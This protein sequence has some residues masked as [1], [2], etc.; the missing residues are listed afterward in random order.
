[1]I[2]FDASL[3]KGFSDSLLRQRYDAPIPTPTL[4]EEMWEMCCSDNKLVAIAA[5]R[6]HAKSTA[7]THAYTL[8][9]ICFR[10][11]KF[12]II[13]SD[14]EAQAVN[15]LGDIKAELLENQDLRGLFG[16]D[17]LLKDNETDCILQYDDGTKC[18][19]IA[20]GA[21]QKLRGLKWRGKRPDLIV[22]DDMENDESVEN[23]ERR[24]KM[25]LWFFKA[26][27][28]S[29][30]PDGVIR[31][32]GTVLHLDALLERLLNDSTW[33]TKRYKAH[34]EDYSEILWP[35]L[36]TKESLKAIQQS[37]I[38]QGMPEGYSCE[39][40]NNPIDVSDRL[41]RDQDFIEMKPEDFNKPMVY[42]ASS[43]FAISQK[44]KADYTVMLV[45]GICPEGYLYI[46]DRIK[47]RMDSEEIIEE[48]INI[49]KRYSPEVFLVEAEKIDKAIGPFLR[50]RMMETGVFINVHTETPTKDKISR[51]SSIAA[52]MKQGAV[53]F[54]KENDWYDNFYEN[55]CVVTRSGVKGAHDDDLDAFAWLGL[56]IDKFWNAP[57]LEEIEEEQYEQERREYMFDG[58]C[59]YTGY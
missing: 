47:G 1:M 55:L 39:Y 43:D 12:I 40:L 58:M 25:R 45:G 41:F 32:V 29:L 35:E 18:R 19:I 26:V 50:K 33:L 59:E 23:P 57:T 10:V 52:R 54:Y 11:R 34:N 37:Y 6:G 22:C 17:R 3:I 27:L 49:Q 2:Q 48:M 53:R 8:A 14:T 30:S 7:V 13:L 56:T 28:P 9:N 36:H 24:E 44:E 31:Y 46:L 16:I 20:K 21:G 38:T 51:A 5:P 15:F 4:H 42:F